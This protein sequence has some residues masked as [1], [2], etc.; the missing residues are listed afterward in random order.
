M[1]AF[2]I[3]LV[4]EDSVGKSSF[5]DRFTEDN[6]VP[7]LMATIGFDI[8]MKT[9]LYDG[10]NLTINIWDTTGQKRFRTITEAYW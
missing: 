2:K 7:D 1:D 9:I 8:K 10:Y 3:L 6:F 5:L 4:G